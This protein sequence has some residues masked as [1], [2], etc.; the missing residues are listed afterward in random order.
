MKS[1][2]PA[3]MASKALFGYSRELAAASNGL[4]GGAQT[5][6]NPDGATRGGGAYAAGGASP[7]GPNQGGGGGGPSVW[8]EVYTDPNPDV[9]IVDLVVVSPTNIVARALV[10]QTFVYSNDAG[11]TWHYVANA[12]PGLSLGSMAAGGGVVCVLGRDGSSV[13]HVGR[14]TDG[15]ATWA[16]VSTPVGFDSIDPIVYVAGSFVVFDINVARVWTSTDGLTWSAT[17]MTTHFQPGNWVRVYDGFV[18]AP[19]NV[20]V[21][22]GEDFS[23]IHGLTVA[24]ND[25]ITFTETTQAAVR[26]LN[27]VSYDGTVFNA[28]GP[29][30]GGPI[31]GLTSSDGGNTW[32]LTNSTGPP[33]YEALNTALAGIG[34]L[35]AQGFGP[36]VVATSTDH[37][38]TYTNVTPTT[39]LTNFGELANDGARAYIVGDGI[40]ATSDLVSFTDELVVAGGNVRSISAGFNMTFAFGDDGTA[41]AIWKRHNTAVVLNAFNTGGVGSTG[42]SFNGPGQTFFSAVTS[43]AGTPSGFSGPGAAPDP[44]TIKGAQLSTFGMISTSPVNLPPNGLG[45]I[46]ILATAGLPQNHFTSVSFTLS[47]GHSYTLTTASADFNTP[48]DDTATTSGWTTWVWPN[49]VEPFFPPPSFSSAITFTL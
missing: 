24:T 7:N 9:S 21:W 39:A 27:S 10:G 35:N 45:F 30:G 11:V 3:G 1:F 19:G 48:W 4:H 36:L 26:Q 14:S 29:Q 42:P 38:V 47:N 28:I 15:G 8:S 22:V 41:P 43:T 13:G 32:S 31:Y 17:A 2:S 33:P 25:A 37:G 18:T 49:S 16:Q 34:I 6:G 46:V 23:N 5:F 44:L 40:I 12:L 20:G